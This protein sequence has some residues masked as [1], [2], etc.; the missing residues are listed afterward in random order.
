MTNLIDMRR[1]LFGLSILCLCSSASVVLAQEDDTGPDDAAESTIRL[2]GAAEAALP[3][4]VTKEIMLPPA[5][6]ENSAAVENAQRGLQR[7]QENRERRENGLSRADQAREHGT[8]MADEA[9]QNR[10][11]RGRFDDRPNPPERPDPPRRPDTPNGP[12]GN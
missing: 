8:E 10:E 9:R 6:M 3:D 12:P 1:L 11:N 4:A 5:V 7:A 2:M